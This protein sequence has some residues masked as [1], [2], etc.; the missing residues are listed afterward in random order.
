MPQDVHFT[1][2]FTSRISPDL[3]GARVRNLDWTWSHDL[4]RGEA[5]LTEYASWD[6]AQAAARTYPEATGADLDMLVNWFGFAFL[7]DDQFD[8]SGDRPSQV[9]A[10]AR[11]MI[12]IPFRPAGTPPDVVC[13]VTLAWAEIWPQMCDGMSETW[14]NRFASNWA[15]FMAAAVCE[16]HLATHRTVM[17]L[18]GYA[19]L[20]QHTVG[21]QHSLDAVE[22]IGRFE[23]PPH[24]QAHPVMRRLRH[25]TTDCIAYMNDVH[26]LDRE[27]DRGDQHNLVTVLQRHLR[28]SRS[29]ALDAAIRMTYDKLAE[30]VDLHTRVPK[31]C[32][33]LQ[34]D[35]TER[36]AVDR[37]V[38]GTG[39]WIRGNYEW[40]LNSGRYTVA[41][42][43]RT[44]VGAAAYLEGLG[45]LRQAG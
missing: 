13:P 19:A 3:E 30:V 23:V 16:I 37:A 12:A 42:P 18:E 14:Q 6:L 34:L 38:Q 22:R 15:R 29:A 24:V 36:S 8:A 1:I 9:S 2:P 43:S 33:E 21:L 32:D 31:M 5:G 26:S 4:V 25:T 11:E 17:D 28:C 40:G 39:D 20:R 44:A 7:F 41:A 10:V 35:E 45:E 27:E